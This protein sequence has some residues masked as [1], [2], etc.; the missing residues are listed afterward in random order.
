[1]S[2]KTYFT[3]EMELRIHMAEDIITSSGLTTEDNELPP[4]FVKN[5]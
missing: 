5:A 1:M 3:P 2:K 4:I